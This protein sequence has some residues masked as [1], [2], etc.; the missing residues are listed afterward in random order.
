M[1]PNEFVK[2]CQWLGQQDGPVDYKAMVLD[3]MRKAKGIEPETMKLIQIYCEDGAEYGLFKY[4]DRE[5]IERDI[6]E[7]HRNAEMAIMEMVSEDDEEENV[8]NIFQN[9]LSEMGIDRVYIESEIYLPV[10]N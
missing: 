4:T 6:R 8:D 1:K 3:I 9:Y 2:H 7:C 10:L 5:D